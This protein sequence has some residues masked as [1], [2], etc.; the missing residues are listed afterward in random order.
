MALKQK[1]ALGQSRT[2]CFKVD[3]RNRP[4]FLHG[5][6]AKKNFP[7]ALL[8]EE[9]LT[10]SLQHRGLSPS[11]FASIK[12][13]AFVEEAGASA[14]RIATEVVVVN[15]VETRRGYRRCQHS[16]SLN[17]HHLQDGLQICFLHIRNL[18]FDDLQN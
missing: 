15:S 9:A 3:Q 13:V 5:I 8:Q 16:G 6:C 12:V 14:V 2:A 17:L 10:I 18:Q 1:K 11:L 7:A 4:Q